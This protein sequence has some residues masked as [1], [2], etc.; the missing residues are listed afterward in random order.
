MS[1]A[2]EAWEIKRRRQELLDMIEEAVGLAEEMTWPPQPIYISNRIRETLIP[3]IFDARTY[4]EVGQITAPE[5][6]ERL[7]AARLVAADLAEEDRGFDRLFSR[8]RAISEEADNAA[9]L[10]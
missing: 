6:R 1:S 7:T 2:F 8:L 5:I 9:R 4:I 3:A 10:A